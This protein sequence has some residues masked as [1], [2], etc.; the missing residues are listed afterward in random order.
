MAT[1]PSATLLVPEGWTRHERGPLTELI[2]PE[3][4]GT[5]EIAD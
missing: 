1:N 4:S 2:A 5:Q 3:A